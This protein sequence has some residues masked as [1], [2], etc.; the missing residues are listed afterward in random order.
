MR[1]GLLLSFLILAFIISIQVPVQAQEE[2]TPTDLILTVYAD[3]VTRVEYIVEPDITYPMVKIMLFGTVYEYLVVEDQDGIPLDY[4]TIEGGVEVYTLGTSSAR[5]TY[6]TSDLTSKSARTWV[7][8][9]SAPI[10]SHIILP[11]EATIIS[12]NQVPVAITTLADQTLLTMPKGEQQITYIIGIVGTKEHA[13]I[14]INDVVTKIQEIKAT[15][16]SV[17]EAEDKLQEARDALNL[18]YYTEAEQLAR[19]AK[20]LAAQ[21]EAIAIEASSHISVGESSIKKAQRE[22]RTTGL[23]EAQDN[24]QQAK[25]YYTDG[26]YEKAIELAERAKIEA[27]KA[28]TPEKTPYLWIL[29]ITTITVMIVYLALKYLKKPKKAIN[30]EEIFRQNPQ[31]RYGDREVIQFLAERG[32]ESLETSIRERFRLPRTTAWRLVKRLQREG[33]I[34]T[35]KVGGQNLIKIKKQY[36]E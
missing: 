34:E 5:I 13:L 33:V 22:G 24:L 20:E 1:K 12:L 30:V 32:G 26:N 2:Y 27:E 16:I 28:T 31:I 4:K 8:T 15:N 3:G 35:Q 18:G 10:N 25:N 19:Q 6:F 14:Q 29:G 11:Q 7:L 21:T 9:I 17:T 36:Q 23:D